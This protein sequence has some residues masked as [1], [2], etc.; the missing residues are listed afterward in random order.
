MPP[1]SDYTSRHPPRRTGSA[2]RPTHPTLHPPLVC[3][4]Y[5]SSAWQAAQPLLHRFESLALEKVSTVVTLWP[6]LLV[7]VSVTVMVAPAARQRRG[8][9]EVAAG[10]MRGA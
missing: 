9:Q 2:G 1:R 3:V 6:P 7:V 8:A 4:L 5:G 10:Q